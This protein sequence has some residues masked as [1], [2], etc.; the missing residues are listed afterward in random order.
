MR[1]AFARLMPEP[2]MDTYTDGVISGLRIV[3]PKWEII[4]LKPHP[5]DRKNNSLLLRVKKYYERFWRFPQHVTQQKADI[6][7]IIDPSEGHIAYRLKAKN[8]PVVITCHDLINF[9][10]RDN[11]K[12]SV[13]LPFVSRAMWLYAIKG[14]KL[15]EHIVAVSSVTAKDTTQILD[16]EPA[17]ISVVP[18]AVDAIYQP[19]PQD[20]VDAIR[21]QYG[22]SPETICLLNVGAVHPRKN[23]SNILKALHILKKRGLPIHFW[24][25]SADF[26]NEQKKFITENGLEK[27]I[28]YLGKLDKTTLIK[29]YSAADI[30]LAPSLYEGFG[31]TILEAMACGTPVITS[32]VSAMPEVVG[33]AGFF[34]EPSNA[35]AIADGV[36]KLY[37]NP[38]HYQELVEK[39]LKRVKSFTW[40]KAAEDIA[41]IYENLVN[42][43][44]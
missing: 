36:D 21:Q 11:L 24:K 40:E 19:S 34:V 18:N 5:V 27:Y 17:R 9:Y 37:H 32:N 33:N 2:S 10:C 7:H 4:D 44:L 14:M 26:T 8:K 43:V 25:V 30:L 38:I 3:R 39:G 42:K 31:L 20:Q 13:E 29:I 28:T 41:Q 35:E 6:F 15:A 16:I 23:V 1:I 22:I 12:G